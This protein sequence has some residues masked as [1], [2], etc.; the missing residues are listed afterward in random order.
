MCLRDSAANNCEDGVGTLGGKL[1]ANE[2]VEP[3][4]RDGVFF[5][6]FRLEKLDE[7]LHGVAEITTDAQLLQ[8][9]HHVL[10]AFPSVS[11]IGKDVPELTVREFVQSAGSTHAEVTPHVCV[12]AEVEFLQGAR[13]RL[14]PCVWVLCCD[15]DSND[16]SLG[17]RSTL[18][19][20]SAGV[21]HV[22]VDFG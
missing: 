18:R 16:V 14:E 19:C 15:S 9:D 5:E 22:K 10:P 12:G 20:I 21:R 8:C 4:S 3:A 11:A 17:A 7:V 1:V 2:F 6:G 13:R